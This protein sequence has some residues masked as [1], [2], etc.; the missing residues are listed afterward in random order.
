MSNKLNRGDFS[1]LIIYYITK[2][3]WRKVVVGTL[4]LTFLAGYLVNKL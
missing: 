3:G 2:I 1:L 4:A